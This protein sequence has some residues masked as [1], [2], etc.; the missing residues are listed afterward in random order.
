MRELDP[1]ELSSKDRYKLLIG[2]ITPRPIAF[3]SS[4]SPDGKTNLAPFSFFNAAGA[5][6]MTLMFCPVTTPE[7]G[8]KDTLRNAR[9]PEEGGVGQFVVNVAVEAYAR[10]VSAAAALLPYGDSEFDMAKL[11][12]APSRVVKPPRLEESPVSFEC[13]TTHVIALAPGVPSSG[14]VV[15]GRV[16]HVWIREDLA[17][18]R[19]RVDPDR[20]QTI[21]RMGGPAYCRTRDRFEL[22]RGHEAL[23]AEPPFE[24][25]R[26][27][28]RLRQWL[29]KGDADHDG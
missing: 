20:L 14:T 18:D 23:R 10:Q 8:E 28:E 21:G 26:G 12:P 24:T 7:G 19:L 5:D 9:P 25:D 22:P 13:E 16:V 2:C 17:D 15:M 1:A 11:T 29:A 6:P 4:V 27:T 3:V